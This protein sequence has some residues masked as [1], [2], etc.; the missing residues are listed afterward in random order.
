[1][2][3]I[4]TPHHLFSIFYTAEICRLGAVRGGLALICGAKP[5]VA[6]PKMSGATGFVLE[7]YAAAFSGLTALSATGSAIKGNFFFFFFGPPDL[8][9][10]PSGYFL[11]LVRFQQAEQ[12]GFIR[13]LGGC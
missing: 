9:N 4:F 10:P 3:A 1:V 6:R 12:V 2:Y 13:L 7:A 5:C 8:F 11:G